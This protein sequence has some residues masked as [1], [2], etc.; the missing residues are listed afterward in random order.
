LVDLISLSE[1][2]ERWQLLE[3]YRTRRA[4]SSG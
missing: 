3:A 4:K 2:S 1:Q